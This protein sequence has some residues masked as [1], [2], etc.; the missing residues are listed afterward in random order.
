MAKSAKAMTSNYDGATL[1]KFIKAVAAHWDDLDAATGTHLNRTG[2]IRKAIAGIVEE[3]KAVGVPKRAFRAQLKLE[4]CK[5]QMKRI[6]EDL[7]REQRD[8]LKQMAEARADRAQQNLFGWIELTA[9]EK[10]EI[11]AAKKKKYSGISGSDLDKAAV[12]AGDTSA[13]ETTAGT[14]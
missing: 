11:K 13:I 8:E 6:L 12:A 9:K 3:A 1:E 10:A 7:E 2:K 4:H 14:A 5:R